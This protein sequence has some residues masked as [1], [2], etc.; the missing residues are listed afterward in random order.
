MI[1][2]LVLW[3]AVV[4]LAVPAT[5][6]KVHNKLPS[7]LDPS[8]A[9]VVV[10]IGKLDNALLPGTLVMGRY[11]SARN[12]I[13][14]ATPPPGGKIPRG[15]WARDN[16]VH[17]L[18]PAMKDKDRALYI[19]ELDPGLW[20]VEGANDTAFSLSSSSVQLAA[21]TVTDLGVVSVYSDFPPGQKRDVLTAGRLMKGALLG[22]IFARRVPAS[23]P[24]A[25]DVR[26]RQ[27]S[28]MPLPPLLA[29][30]RPVV[31]AGEVRFGNHLGGLVNRM[32]GR[33]ARFR[34]LAAEQAIEAAEQAT[35][36]P[37]ASSDEAV[38]G[39]QP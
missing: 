21:G 26:A 12:D 24:K 5:A 14:E 16:R 28:D 17:L 27:A 34:A 19:A 6:S 13:A 7:S 39:G 29:E 31:W 15:G 9:Y 1:R 11:D 33:K 32:G 22:G 20:V 2:Y 38:T 30:A 23:M 35:A 8:K 36:E 3:L 10:E 18:K 25:I 4:T 37:R